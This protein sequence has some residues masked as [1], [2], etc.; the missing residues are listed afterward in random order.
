MIHHHSLCW[1]E[2]VR[3]DFVVRET[4]GVDFLVL[5]DMWIYQD[6][7]CIRMDKSGSRC[8]ASSGICWVILVCVEV[9]DLEIPLG[10]YIIDISVRPHSINT[11]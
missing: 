10:L 3:S 4:T 11:I 1:K 8:D 7:I 6:S 9:T 5:E 2:P